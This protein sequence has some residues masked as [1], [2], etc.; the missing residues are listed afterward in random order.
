M[1][2]LLFDLAKFSQSLQY[3]LSFVVIVVAILAN[4]VINFMPSFFYRINCIIYSFS[5]ASDEFG[6]R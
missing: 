2:C 1:Y 6:D 5:S 4:L 3:H